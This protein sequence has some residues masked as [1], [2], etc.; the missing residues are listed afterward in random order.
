LFYLPR[1]QQRH[2]ALHLV[3]AFGLWLG[4]TRQMGF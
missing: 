3:R 4:S 2:R 1:I